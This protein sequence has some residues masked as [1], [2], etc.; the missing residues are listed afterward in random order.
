MPI[1]TYFTVLLAGP[2]QVVRSYWSGILSDGCSL[3]VP[4][5]MTF[6][7]SLAP[8]VAVIAVQDV[9]ESEFSNAQL[10][11]TAEGFT[12]GDTALPRGHYKGYGRE[13]ERIW[14]ERSIGPTTREIS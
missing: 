12:L 8:F 5:E 13:L 2:Y 11:A 3:E 7:A 6:R 9:Q 14:S 1:S 10:S 4:L